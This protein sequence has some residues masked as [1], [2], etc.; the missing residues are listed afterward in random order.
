MTKTTEELKQ[1]YRKAFGYGLWEDAEKGMVSRDH[2]VLTFLQSEI[3]A[4]E[5]AK[6]KQFKEATV[7]FFKEQK[8]IAQIR[9]DAFWV[10]EFDLQ[11]FGQ[12]LN[13][14]SLFLKNPEQ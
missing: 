7:K 13:G 2:E 1:R 4:A 10:H 9:G 14:C 3:E 5:K 8:E 11:I 12:P 6:E